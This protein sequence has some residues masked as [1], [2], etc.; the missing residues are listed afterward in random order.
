MRRRKKLT[1][2]KMMIKR[3]TKVSIFM[4]WFNA[5]C[6]FFLLF[7]GIGLIKNGDLTPVGGWLP[8]LIR[9]IFFSGENLLLAHV[10]CGFTWILVFIV[11]TIV[12]LRKEVSYFIREIFTFSPINDIS[13][14]IKKGIQ[15]TFGYK[16]LTRLGLEPKIPDQGFYNVG[17]K[18]F[19]IPAVLGG[20]VIAATGIVMYSSK[21]IMMDTSIVQWS[22][23]IH[24]VMVGVVFAG[25]L[26]HIYMASI[27]AGE[28]PALISMFTG[29]VPEEYAEHH[30]KLW[31]NTIKE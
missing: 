19:A 16:M 13:W 24:F 17:Q 18:L 14:I 7:T 31:Y 23:L 8:D 22:I 10:I 2:V 11:F 26:I 12:R 15:M 3:H 9:G 20:I 1:M 27:A 6:W 21:F 25:L 5:V 4:H 29:S 30:H 28:L